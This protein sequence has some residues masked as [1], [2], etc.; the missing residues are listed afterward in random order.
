M[1]YRGA[2]NDQKA[3][4]KSKKIFRDSSSFFNSILGSQSDKPKSNEQKFI[5]SFLWAPDEYPR[6]KIA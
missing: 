4:N 2:I 5:W 1:G 3:Q 6:W